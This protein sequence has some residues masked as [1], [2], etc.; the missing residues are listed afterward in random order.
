MPVTGQCELVFRALTIFED[1]IGKSINLKQQLSGTAWA[2]AVGEI[3]Y[4]MMY[5]FKFQERIKNWPYPT[6]YKRLI[7]YKSDFDISHPSQ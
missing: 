5:V 2:S 7:K 3:K 4:I 6:M 1:G